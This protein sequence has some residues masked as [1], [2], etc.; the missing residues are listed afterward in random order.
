MKNAINKWVMV[1]TAFAGLAAL[2]SMASAQTY[3]YGNGYNNYG[4][5]TAHAKCKSNEQ[6][7][8]VAGA[9]IGGILGA[10]AGSQVSGD[11]ARTEGSAIGAVAGGLLGAGIA[12]KS[13]DCDP[14]YADYYGNQPT[15]DPYYSS[16]GQTTYGNGSYEN[17]G[18]YGTQNPYPSG[19]VVTTQQP[20]SSDPY[21][22]S[23]N[24]VYTQTGYNSG[25]YRPVYGSTTTYS[26][27]AYRTSPP[28]H[29]KAH[30]HHKKRK[31]RARQVYRQ[32]HATS[33]HYHGDYICFETH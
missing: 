30:G 11:G 7:K 26:G 16:G 21:Y 2:P 6:D 15:Y 31:Q 29:A 5:H 20:Y 18:Y 33:Q 25:A 9:V 32:Q 4:D 12:D 3:S 17:S 19:R 24:R 23:G 27:G 22:T 14:E 1:S 28:R 8:K 13:I 10:V